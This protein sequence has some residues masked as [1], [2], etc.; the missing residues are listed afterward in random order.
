MSLFTSVVSV[1]S[2]SSCKNLP[3]Y[4]SAG[5][6]RSGSARTVEIPYPF[7]VPLALRLPVRNLSINVPPSTG[8]A[9]GTP[10]NALF[11]VLT[12]RQQVLTQNL[13]TIRLKPTNDCPKIA[14]KNTRNAKRKA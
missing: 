9:S 10:S 3:A 8:K 14:A 2:V 7:R 6:H 1:S 5:H 12:T 11:V 13:A 4:W